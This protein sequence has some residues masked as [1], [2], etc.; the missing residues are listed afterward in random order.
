MIYTQAQFD[1]L[2]KWAQ[3]LVAEAG[4]KTEYANTL[5]AD[6]NAFNARVSAEAAQAALD[7]PGDQVSWRGRVVAV[8]DPYEGRVP[9]ARERDVVRFYYDATNDRRWVD[10]AARNGAVEIMARSSVSIRAQAS[11]TFRI[12]TEG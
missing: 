2:P 10:V 12:T 6:A 1:R 11:N 3:H 5:I 7:G 8:R 4:R 9:I